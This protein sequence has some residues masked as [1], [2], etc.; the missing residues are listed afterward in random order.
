M[1]P[2]AVLRS[3]G[4]VFVV[5]TSRSGPHF[6]PELFRAA[7]FD[8]FAASVL[9]AKSPCGFRAAYAPRAARIMVV[10]APGCAPSD[11]W[12][13]PFANIPRPL[14][15]WDDLESGCPVPAEKPGFS[16]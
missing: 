1:G 14:W 15:P 6:A 9:V 7:G 3:G 13:Y 8:P 4:N 16:A 12:H 5:A 2:S 11:F 10:R